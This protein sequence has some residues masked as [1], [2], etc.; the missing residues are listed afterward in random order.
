MQFFALVILAGLALLNDPGAEKANRGG[1]EAILL[2][3]SK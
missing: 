2:P 1:I 3:Q